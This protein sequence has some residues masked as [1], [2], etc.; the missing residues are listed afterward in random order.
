M[1]NI[2]GNRV[3]IYD[4]KVY[5]GLHAINEINKDKTFV[6]CCYVEVSNR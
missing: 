3:K 5:E 2:N 1:M 4:K 6:I